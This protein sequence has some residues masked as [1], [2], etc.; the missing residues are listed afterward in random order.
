[1]VEQGLSFTVIEAPHPL[2][3]PESI[4]SYNARQQFSVAHRVWL[5]WNH[6]TDWLHDAVEDELGEDAAWYDVQS[7]RDATHVGAAGEIATVV[8]IL[9]GVGAADILR[10]FYQG[11]VQRLGEASAEALLDWARNKSKERRQA[12]G[13]EQADGPPDFGDYGDIDGLALG[14]TGELADVLPV[15]EDQ[16]ELVSAERRESAALY[17]VYRDRLTGTKY[18]VEA[19]RDSASFRRLSDQGI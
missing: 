12:T 10:T 18:S 17:A 1:M 11:F 5:G 6:G 7:K 16:L 13:M 14:M 3:D 19:Q 4:S 2:D 15:P 8:L 9:M